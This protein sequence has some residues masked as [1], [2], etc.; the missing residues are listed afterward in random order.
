MT[1]SFTTNYYMSV[2]LAIKC[3]HVA[4]KLAL[5]KP[6]LLIATIDAIGK[7]KFVDNKI[8][9]DFLKEYYNNI[10]NEFRCKQTPMSYPYYF[11]G[12]ESFWNLKWNCVPIS[13]KSPTEKM[14]REKVDYAYLDNDLWNLLQDAD[15]REI[16]KEAILNHFFKETIANETTT[17]NSIPK[18]STLTTI[19]NKAYSIYRRYYRNVTNKERVDFLKVARVVSSLTYDEL[20]RCMEGEKLKTKE[21]I[22]L[23]EKKIRDEKEFD[24]NNNEIKEFELS[25]AAE[26]GND[27]SFKDKA[28]P[29]QLWALK[30]VTGIDYRDAGLT[31]RQASEMLASANYESQ[32]KDTDSEEEA[33]PRQL[34]ALRC[35]TG[36]DHR[37]EGLT[38]TQAA[39]MIE[40]ACKKNG[41]TKKRDNQVEI[42]D[43]EYDI[44]RRKRQKRV[45]YSD[46]NAEA[47]EAYM[48][49]LKEKRKEERDR[50]IKP[51]SLEDILS[52]CK[53]REEQLE[54]ARKFFGENK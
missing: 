26:Q 1:T 35:A 2:I 27:Y 6:A 8:F 43:E 48:K 24:I 31:K 12:S 52:R 50:M 5:A 47:G 23:I 20:T 51:G 17:I 46:G 22:L 11:M 21:T 30:K 19:H 54:A 7:K 15:S 36:V 10:C 28:T 49:A 40:E 14:I 41:Y 44:T 37:G 9:Y 33:T 25:M 29:R 45:D 16:L 38:K 13:T 3:A 39:Q 18:T 34:W 42:E 53:T 4:G 32:K